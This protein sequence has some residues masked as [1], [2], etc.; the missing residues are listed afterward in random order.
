MCN[1]HT[2]VQTCVASAYIYQHHLGHGCR[3]WPMHLTDDLLWDLP[4][5]SNFSMQRGKSYASQPLNALQ[6][7]KRCNGRKGWPG[8]VREAWMG[9]PSHGAKRVLAGL[10]LYWTINTVE[11]ATVH[12]YSLAYAV[13]VPGVPHS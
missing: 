2:G 12:V 6:V 1:F 11:V 5:V 9:G 10:C 4:P 13:S 3:V 7:R 8:E